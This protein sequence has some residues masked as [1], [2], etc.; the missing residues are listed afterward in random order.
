M[1]EIKKEN[2][3]YKTFIV[4]SLLICPVV[5]IAPLGSWIPL[6]VLAISCALFNKSIYKKKNI[7]ETPIAIFIAF[8]WIIVSTI[9]I[10]KNYF[11]LEK[12]FYFILQILFGLIILKTD[13]NSSNLKKIIVV[14]SI[15]FILSVILIIIDSKINLGLKLWLSKNLDFSNFKSFYE[16]KGWTSLNDFRKN[17]FHQILS[18]NNSAYSRGIISLTVLAFPLSLLCFFYNKKLIAYIVIILSFLLVFSVSKLTIILSLFVTFIFGL[19]FYFQNTLLRKYLFW[20]LGIYFFSCPLILGKLDYKKFS[21][22]ENQLINKRN[23]LIKQYCHGDIS[24]HVLNRKKYFLFL[25]CNDSNKQYNASILFQNENAIEKI[26]IF[27]MY[28]LYSTASK[29][30]HRLMIW[31]YV[32]EKILEKPLFGYGFFSSRNI[33]NE[34][35]NT[36]IGT[37]YQLIPLHPHNSILQIWLEL[38]IVGIIIFFSIIKFILDRIFYYVQINRTVATIAFISFFQIFTVG[39]IS[40]G[41]WQHWWL[42]IILIA[43]ILYK[44]VFI[45]FK[46]H[47][48]QSDSLD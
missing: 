47:V 28:N 17:N 24:Q 39:Q 32:K 20:F 48:S 4:I 11:I 33:S 42:A 6:A 27:L 9:F 36:Q 43:L 25:Y 31:S 26:R 44:Y 37:K 38:G 14:F 34:M 23:D 40:F 45:S 5:V 2:F 18:Y 13:I 41:F 35:R 3:I 46:S 16:L 1:L 8:F 22:Y 19:I 10:G 12:A 21:E 7:L 29:K 15:S 30:L